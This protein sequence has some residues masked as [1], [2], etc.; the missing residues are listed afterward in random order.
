MS[1]TPEELDSMRVEAQY[2]EK[3]ATV[4]MADCIRYAADTIAAAI[5]TAKLDADLDELATKLLDKHE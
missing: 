3:R 2:N 4:Y 5:R 1:P